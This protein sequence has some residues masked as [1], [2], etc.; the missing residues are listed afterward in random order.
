MLEH[1]AVARAVHWLETKSM[2][3]IS[4]QKEEPVV[5]VLVVAADLPEIN[6]EQIG[7]NNLLVASL[8]VFSL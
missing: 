8:S 4:F 2:V 6:M 7:G 1:Q 5:V 3:F